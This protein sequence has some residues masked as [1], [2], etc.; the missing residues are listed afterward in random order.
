[1]K[2]EFGPTYWCRYQYFLELFPQYG[3]EGDSFNK[4]IENYL[5][6]CGITMEEIEKFRQIMLE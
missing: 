5:L 6:S 1:M 3:K 4:M 2:E